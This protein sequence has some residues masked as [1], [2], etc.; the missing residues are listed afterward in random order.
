MVQVMAWRHLWYSLLAQKR[1]RMYVSFGTNHYKLLNCGYHQTLNQDIYT[2]QIICWRHGSDLT[3]KLI[4]AAT[5]GNVHNVYAK[6]ILIK[7]LNHNCYGSLKYWKYWKSVW[8][9]SWLYFCQSYFKSHPIIL[10]SCIFKILKV[11]VAH[12][13]CFELIKL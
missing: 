5:L 8:Y 1:L 2:N 9:S 6:P 4:S 12:K 11:I 13:G 3:G 10:D 7:K